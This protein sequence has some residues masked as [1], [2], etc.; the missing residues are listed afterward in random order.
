MKKVIILFIFLSIFLVA[1]ADEVKKPVAILGYG[2]PITAVEYR[3]FKPESIE[4]KVFDD[5]LQ[6]SEYYNFSVIYMAERIGQLPTVK[7]NKGNMWTDP[8]VL[9][10]VEEYLKSGG[11]IIITCCAFDGL[12]EG[13]NLGAISHLLG[14]GYYP[15]YPRGKSPYKVKIVNKKSPITAHLK[16]EEYD[17]IADTTPISNVSSAE[18]LAVQVDEN[19]EV[20]SPFITENIIGKGKVYWF[21]TPL[22]RLYQKKQLDPE[23][24]EYRNT[25]FQAILQGNPARGEIKKEKWEPI[26]LGGKK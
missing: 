21:G 4:Y 23:V 8:E 13:R 9:K 15:R 19:G 11:V 25:L 26:P 18:V 1:L 7:E 3:I 17:W 16:K 6:P 5:W 10:K 24:E 2:G 20:L 22:F 12:A 14:F